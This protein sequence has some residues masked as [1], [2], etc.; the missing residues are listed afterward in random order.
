MPAEGLVAAS[1]RAVRPSAATD[2]EI[3]SRN[4]QTRS[5]RD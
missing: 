4:D 5:N 2:L 3:C 1:I